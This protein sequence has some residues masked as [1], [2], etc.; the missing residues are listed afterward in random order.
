M[1]EASP[2]GKGLPHKFGPYPKMVWGHSLQHMA[3]FGALTTGFC[4]VFDSPTFI[5]LT[6]DPVLGGPG[7]G[8]GP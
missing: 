4:M 6:P 2:N 7:Q 8:L 5:V 1:A 3:P